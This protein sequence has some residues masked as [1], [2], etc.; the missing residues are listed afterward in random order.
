ML[1]K[2]CLRTSS[3]FK[4]LFFKK[5][6]SLNVC[7]SIKPGVWLV[8]EV[9]VCTGHLREIIL[10]FLQEKNTILHSLLLDNGVLHDGAL[11]S[12]FILI[13]QMQFLHRLFA[14][15]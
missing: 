10:K 7:V 2:E 5:K 8:L 12:F 9:S 14:S 13:L 3:T 1:V 4:K 11:I 6:L 15:E